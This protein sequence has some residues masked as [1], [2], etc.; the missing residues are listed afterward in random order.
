M[1]MAGA[2]GGGGPPPVGSF[3]AAPPPPEPEAVEPD[4]AWLDFDA[5][6]LAG[7]GEARRGRLT[8]G[9]GA[10]GGRERGDAAARIER[11]VPAPGVVDPCASRG[12]FD[13][14]YEAEGVAEVPSDGLARRVPL[15]LASG[16]PGTRLRAVPREVP[17]VYRE[18]EL[19]NP[20]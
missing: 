14:R 19:Q 2:P 18:V 3:G 12:S 9:G 7:P 8:Q 5:L 6:S 16:T 20:F 11:L 15:L 10:P 1:D 4:D 17:E 13:H